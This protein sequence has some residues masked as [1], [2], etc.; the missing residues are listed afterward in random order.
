MFLLLMYEATA[1]QQNHTGLRMSK[2]KRR[3]LD[4]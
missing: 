2:K 4:L 3:E 1:Y